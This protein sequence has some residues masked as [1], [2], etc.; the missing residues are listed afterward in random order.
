MY[1]NL[2]NIGFYTAKDLQPWRKWY[3]QRLNRAILCG[4][5][6]LPFYIPN[7]SG[8]FPASIDLYNSDDTKVATFAPAG[9]ISHEIEVD[10]ETANIWIYQG[11]QSGIMGYLPDPGCY[12]V[13][14]GQYWSDMF[15]IGT[16]P[17][18]RV[19]ISAQL[20]DDIITADG[21][22]I[23]KH[24]KYKFIFPADINGPAY[25]VAETVKENNGV[26][27]PLVS[28]T[29][30]TILFNVNTTETIADALQV[31]RIADEIKIKIVQN[32]IEKNYNSNTFQ[33]TVKWQT[34]EIASVDCE[35]EVFNIIRKNQKSSIAP[36]PL[37][38]GPTPPPV[39]EVDVITGDALS[40]VETVVLEINNETVNVDVENGVYRY[41]SELPTT[42]VR[43][44]S[45]VKTI[46]IDTINDTITDIN[47]SNNT[48][49]TSVKFNNAMSNVTQW[50]LM[51]ENCTA[52]K[53]VNF[54]GGGT[55][56]DKE[57]QGIFNGCT[58]LESADISMF[59]G[60][61]Q[62]YRAFRNC[63]SLLFVVLTENATYNA[64]SMFENAHGTI[65]DFKKY[66]FSNIKSTFKGAT[67]T[68]IRINIDRVVDFATGS[69][70]ANCTFQ[71]TNCDNVE[72]TGI[73]PDT[74]HIQINFGL[75]NTTNLVAQTNSLKKDPN[76]KFADSLSYLSMA[77][78]I[79]ATVSN[80]NLYFSPIAWGNLSS[81]QKQ[82]L[83]IQATNKNITLHY[84]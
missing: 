3:A 80:N 8:D 35:F 32:G 42:K 21:T 67:A 81:S 44:T 20:Y 79:G 61:V 65:F 40:G 56:F 62:A 12:Y 82:L 55:L 28:T 71:N 10:G 38:P 49:I 2:S 11:D 46:E 48:D 47:F 14:I 63:T 57:I 53:S 26:I 22:P 15:A 68:Q 64:D 77:N 72:L 24:L 58:A 60:D 7:A 29:K 51:F 16:L 83:E 66:H 31:V 73:M 52:L 43:I 17:D 74:T 39:V 1:F 36:E 5:N 59:R 76:F 33:T 27:F 70:T 34:D 9:G 45:G 18:N 78:V 4:N 41:E 37:T 25:E 50:R 54:A 19:E 69:L 30:K 6:L 84:D 23:S 13:K 75:Q